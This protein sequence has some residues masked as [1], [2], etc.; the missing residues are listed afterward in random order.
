[1]T[2]CA[3][4]ARLLTA[5]RVLASCPLCVAYA[6]ERGRLLAERRDQRATRQRAA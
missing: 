1:M 4:H 5:G 3:S 2:L 6:A